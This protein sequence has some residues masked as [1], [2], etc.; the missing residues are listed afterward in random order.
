MD[1]H[2]SPRE[3]YIM[4]SEHFVKPYLSVDFFGQAAVNLIKS[5][6][7]PD[8]IVFSD[9]GFLDEVEPLIKEFGAEKLL[10]VRIFR[11]FH[12]FDESDSRDYWHHPEVKS[13]EFNNWGLLEDLPIMVETQLKP[14]INFLNR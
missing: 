9:S 5:I 1:R 6:T 4:L 7:E 3:L 8:T 12:R 11:R 13:V 2:Y 10:Q 14:H